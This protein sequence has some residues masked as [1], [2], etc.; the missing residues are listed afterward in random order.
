MTCDQDS[1]DRA[2]KNW[3]RIAGAALS[4]HS[5]PWVNV[6]TDEPIEL[7]KRHRYIEGKWVTD[8][9]LVRIEKEPFTGGA[10]RHCFRMKKLPQAPNQSIAVAVDWTQSHNLV[11]K[12]FKAPTDDKFYYKD[13]AMQA[14]AT[15]WAMLFNSRDPPK[16]IDMM[17][18]YIVEFTGRQGSPIFAV[19][20]FITGQPCTMTVSC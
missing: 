5:D 4:S 10:M 15:K 19:E 3:Q 7:V 6:F 14:E 8:S 11:A 12:R 9:A 13:V 17:R 1:H 2:S 20:R 16:Q 18:T